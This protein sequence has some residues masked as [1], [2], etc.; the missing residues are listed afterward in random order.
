MREKFIRFMYG[1]NGV[2]DLAKFESTILWIP[3]ILSIFIRQPIIDL[4]L[5]WIMLGLIG[6]TYFRIFSKNT[7]KRYQENQKFRNFRY[8]FAVDKAR[9]KKHFADMKTYKYFKCPM[10]KQKV[11]VPRGHGR[12]SIT[13]PKCREEFIRKS[14]FG[15]IYVWVYQC[16]QQRIV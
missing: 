8:K 13:C 2:D 4:I 15:G 3:L 1:R 5:V 14:Q 16:E 9:K 11:R 6:H 10:C 7:S 12:I